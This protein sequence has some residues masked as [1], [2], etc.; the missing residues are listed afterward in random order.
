M[1][2]DI[3]HH[4]LGIAVSRRGT[5]RLVGA[6]REALSNGTPVHVSRIPVDRN[7]EARVV[8][9]SDA[10]TGQIYFGLKLTEPLTNWPA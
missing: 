10:G 2:R 6:L 5:W 4:G 3:S 1:L 8:W 9:V 7:R